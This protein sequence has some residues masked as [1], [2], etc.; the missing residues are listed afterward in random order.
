[1]GRPFKFLELLPKQAGEIK[2][3]LD[4]P[5]SEAERIRAQAIWCSHNRT[6]IPKIA[7]LLRRTDRSVRKW[8]NAYLA[9]GLDAI[10]A[11]PRPG[12]PPRLKK[13]QV[14]AMEKVVR[15]TPESV[16]VKGL[17]WNC[18]LLVEW[19][20]KKYGV[21]ISDERVRQLLL[22]RNLRFSRPKLK[23]TSPD[24]EYAKKKRLSIA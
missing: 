16:G 24:P 22:A 3:F 9:S 13:E 21:G 19:L 10:R 5:P 11:K 23:I 2:V 15:Q 18:S 17:N 4:D 20:D 7:L 14:D 8:L 6:T 12:R 1:M